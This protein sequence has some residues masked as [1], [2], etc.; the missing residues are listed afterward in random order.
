MTKLQTVCS[1]NT[2]DIRSF[3]CT[4]KISVSKLKVNV[5]RLL[6]MYKKDSYVCFTINDSNNKFAKPF[7]RRGVKQMQIF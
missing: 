5:L 1:P 6:A 3:K 4:S 2:V 7:S